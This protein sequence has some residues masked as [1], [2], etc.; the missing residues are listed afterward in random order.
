MLPDPTARVRMSN[1]VLMSHAE[2]ALT[3]TT[4]VLSVRHPLVWL[5][6]VLAIGLGLRGQNLNHSL[7][8]DEFPPLY[9]VAERHSDSHDMTPA[10]AE[11]LKPIASLQEVRER[12][13]LPYGIV[14][15]V[16]VYHYLLSFVVRVLPVSEWSLRLPSLMAGLACIVGVFIIANVVACRFFPGV[17]DP[18]KC[19]RG[20]A[21]RAPGPGRGFHRPATW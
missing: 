8:L 5:F 13:V 20:T 10:A 4:P 7:E 12:S 19:N 2:P 16:P 3:P 1:A 15:P 21:G 14:N 17:T 6:V 18:G 11:P 9:A